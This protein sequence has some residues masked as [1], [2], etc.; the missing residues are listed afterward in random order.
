M[1]YY[2][3]I[4]KILSK[5]YKPGYLILSPSDFGYNNILLNS[6]KLM[7]LD[8]EYSGLDDPL[9]LCFDFIANPNTK[10]SNIEN[11]I[12]LKKFSNKLKINN[13]KKVLMTLLIFIILNGLL[14]S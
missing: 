13:L 10:F 9:K 8:F 5:K 3:F 6:N 12:F 7:F 2:L 4:K 1:K 11:E 14:L